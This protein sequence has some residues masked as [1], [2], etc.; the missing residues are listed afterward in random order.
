MKL[1]H[2]LMYMR[3]AEAAAETSSAVRLKVGCCLVKN[4]AVIAVSYNGLPSFLDGPIEDKVYLAGGGAW[5][6]PDEILETYPYKDDVDRYKL[7]TKKECRH[8]EKN[9]LLALS[10]SNES[11]TGASLFCTHACCELCSIDIIDSGIVKVY[12]RNEYRSTEG[13]EYLRA[14]NIEVIK[15]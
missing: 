1:K 13:L 7:V 11:A 8:A 15:I 14:N 4:N 2:Q 5:L 10:K 6:D 9:S 3:I 12:Y